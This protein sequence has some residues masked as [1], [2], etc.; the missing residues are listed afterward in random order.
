MKRDLIL[1]ASMFAILSAMAAPAAAQTADEAAPQPASDEA[2]VI[3]VTGE[4]T[5]RS[6]QDT[7]T[8]VGIVTGETIETQGITSLSEA[9]D[10]IANVNLGNTEGGF[11]IRG[12][13]FDNLLGAG[14]SPLAQ[15][16][17][18][19]VTLSDQSTRFGAEGIWDVSQIEVLRGAQSTVQGRN[20]LAGSIVIRTNDPTFDWEGKARVIGLTADGGDE[21]AV[22]GAL[23]GPII[24][25]V[26]AF[27]VA[28]ERRE[29]DGFVSN[30]ITGGDD[31]NDQWTGR[32]KLLFTPTPDI[33]SL[34]TYAYI[35]VDVANRVSDRRS[36]GAD[37]FVNFEDVVP[38]NEFNRE[39]FLN[40]PDSNRN[41]QHNLSW[42]TDWD[43]SQAVRLTS[44]TT[45]SDGVIEE[46]LDSDGTFLNPAL[47]PTAPIV[48]NDP[49][50]IPFVPTGP[51]VFNTEA[52]QNETQTIFTQ[53][54]IA[55]FDNDGPLRGLIGAYYV[56]SK[57]DEF[58][59]TPGVQPGILGTV[60]GAVRPGLQAG[61]TAQLG[62]LRGIPAA[63][64]PVAAI[65]AGPAGDAA[66]AA[67][68]A[69]ATQL[70]VDATLANY[71]DLGTFVA[72]TSEPLD[73]ENYAVYISGEYDILP[74]LTLGIGLRYDY[75]EQVEGLTIIGQPLGLP[76]PAAPF[77]PP[78]FP[79]ALI[80]GVRGSIASVN[81][82]FDATLA[83]AST[84]A[85][86]NFSA[87][88]PSGFLRWEIDADRSVAF[89]VRRGYRSGGSDLNI[90]RQFVSQFDPEYTTNYEIAFRSFFFDR[91]L[92]VNA[93]AFY[94]DWTDQQVVV[95]LSTLQQDEVGFNVGSSTVQ[96]FE[97]EAYL[98]PADGWFIQGVLGY[99]DTQFNDFDAALAATLIEA[100]NVLAP[101]NLEQTLS[102]F[103][104]REFAFAP[105]WSG[106]ARIGY[107]D[108]ATGLF[109]V[110]GV[111]YQAASNVNNA[112][113]ASPT[114]LDNDA[115][116]LVNATLGINF[117]AVTV[118]LVGR[119][120]LDED[121]VAS[122]GDAL[123]RLGPQRQIGLQIQARF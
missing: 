46:R 2:G 108:E 58:N 62:P 27:R 53:E 93:N 83:E 54:L 6:L 73:I 25:G 103:E 88:L 43:I 67:F 71:R 42:K 12:I 47:F 66:F 64:N 31:F 91:K 112:Q 76:N 39:T 63:G 100:Q 8:S 51:Y 87:L 104:G 81:G 97:V 37:G 110:L 118:S 98:T 19:D 74:S 36:R 16:Y 10:Y 79:A 111:T 29:S 4:K 105:D 55:A 65:P 72:A 86:Q 106:A 70:S 77:I 18:D 49:F 45:Y 96:G 23:G 48:I 123:V 121:Y 56:S 7:V 30:P 89:S 28:G 41:I 17:V 69:Q 50:G 85:S 9:F 117:D 80:P 40:S 35:D 44:I 120:L 3:I 14:S 15:I 52:T 122:G 59:F 1:T 61:L 34:L 22:S 60:A 26:L 75:E 113:S 38:G 68:I 33:R 101:I 90:V 119:N 94:T 115:R 92:R 78:G 84:S 11:S 32:V 114:F 5:D 116:V 20:A 21:F 82:F 24:D 57:E 109:G 107:D 102:A 95:S 13:P 99:A